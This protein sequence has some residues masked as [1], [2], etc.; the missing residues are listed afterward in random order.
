MSEWT[1]CEIAGPI[2]SLRGIDVRRCGIGAGN[3]AA[4][5]EE[6]D[7]CPGPDAFSVVIAARLLC[8]YAEVKRQ[9]PDTTC[10]GCTGGN[11]K[12]P[13]EPRC[14]YVDALD[15]IARARLIVENGMDEIE[16]GG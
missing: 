15:A 5:R 12:P 14:L 8:V 3:R 4:T 13:G 2:E 11:G 10:D 9:G 16:T 6:C 7:L 1:E